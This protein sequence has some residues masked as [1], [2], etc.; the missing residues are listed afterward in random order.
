M[1]LGAGNRTLSGGGEGGGAVNA[2]SGEGRDVR[3]GATPPRLVADAA[4][5]CNCT[6]VSHQCYGSK[7]G[8]MWEKESLRLGSLEMDDDGW[9]CKDAVGNQTG[10]GAG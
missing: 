8:V 9:G 2:N 3:I 7:T 10:N 6:Y 4:C 5:P 1:L